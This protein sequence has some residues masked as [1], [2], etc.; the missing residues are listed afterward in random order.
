MLQSAGEK[1][2][3]VKKPGIKIH[4]DKKQ[5]EKLHIYKKPGEKL[6]IHKKPGVKLHIEKSQTKNS[7]MINRWKHY[8]DKHKNITMVSSQVNDSTL[9]N[10]GKKVH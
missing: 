5:C 9:R 4:I 2:H 1:F 8:I 6:Y 10:I 7:T 3:I